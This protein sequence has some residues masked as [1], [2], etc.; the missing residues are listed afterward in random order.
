[1]IEAIF[2]NRA[3]YAEELRLNVNLKGTQFWVRYTF[4]DGFVRVLHCKQVPQFSSNGLN[5]TVS[6]FDVYFV[7]THD[8]TAAALIF[9]T[10]GAD[11][12]LGIFFENPR[13]TDGFGLV[14]TWISLPK[15]ELILP[16]KSDYGLEINL[17]TICKRIS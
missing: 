4:T 14:S 15:R 11:P 2:N 10:E 17:E 6:I 16:I 9:L 5:L 12:T 3:I 1:M 13:S 8:V 7:T